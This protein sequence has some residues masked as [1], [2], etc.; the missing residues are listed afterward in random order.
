ME[1]LLLVVGTAAL[2]GA[3]TW[4]VIRTEMKYLRRDVNHAHKRLDDYVA[5]RLR[6]KSVR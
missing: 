1:T 5:D 3:V 4:G 2:N 6:L